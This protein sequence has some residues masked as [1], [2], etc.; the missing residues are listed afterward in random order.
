MECPP[1]FPAGYYWY[2][3]RQCGPGNPFKLVD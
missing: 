1:E 3:G 2:G